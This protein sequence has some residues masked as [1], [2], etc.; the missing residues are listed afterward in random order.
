MPDER[1]I[2]SDGTVRLGIFNEPV[3]EVNYRDY[4]LTTPFGRPAGRW[5]RHF[6]FKQFQFLG[7]LCDEL[8]FGCAI[9]DV[10]YAGTAF[11]YLYEP[12]TRRLVEHSFQMPLGLGIGFDQAPET[13][14][15]TFRSRRAEIE[16]SAGSAPPHRRLTARVAGGPSI[17]AQFD[18]ATPRQQPLRICTRT[19]MT[20]WVFARK[21]AGMPVSGTVRWNGRTLDLAAIGAR[22]HCDWS[23][24]Y[25]RRETFWNWGCLAGTAGDGRALGLNVSCG[26]NETSFTENCFWVDGV[27]HKL[28]SV[29]FDYDRRDLMKP[30]RLHS[31]DGRLALDFEPQA[32]HAENINAGI[33]A[34][35]FNQLLGRYRGRLA[36]AA[37]EEIQ[38]NEMLGY[39]ESHYAKW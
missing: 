5:A 21:T 32:S 23:A 11:V 3:A 35:N 38:L 39:A 4:V 6:G 15:A 24:G 14:R 29:A 31:F 2:V 34:S 28:D 9:A 12:A 36:T 13:G 22:G 30:W 19:G 1:L 25:M 26:V 27:L 10:K 8:V 33:I 7:A 20:G 18:E 37:G 17:E 16:M